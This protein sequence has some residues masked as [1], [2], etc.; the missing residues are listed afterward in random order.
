MTQTR[1]EPVRVLIIEDSDT[2]RYILSH[3]ISGDRRLQVVGAVSTAEEALMVLPKLS[4]DVISMDVR[5]PGM[6][7]IEATRRIMNE[8]PTPIVMIAGVGEDDAA[9][10][11]MQALRAGALALVE[12]PVGP[13]SEAFRDIAE[14]IRTQLYIMSQVPVIRRREAYVRE[15]RLRRRP[16]VT[17]PVPRACLETS[18]QGG[19]EI[20][21][22]AASTGGPPAFARLFSQ[23]PVD[24]P[25]P[26]VLVQHMGARFMDS[27][28]SWLDS[29][30]P[31]PVRIAAD[32]EMPESG[33]IHVAPG[34]CHL[35]VSLARRLSVTEDAPYRGQRPSANRLFQSV[36]ETY[37]PTAVGVL[38]TGMGDDGAEGLLA[39]RDAGAFTMAEDESSAVVYGMPQVAM[40][41]GAVCYSGP[42]DAIAG[43]LA[44][45]GSPQK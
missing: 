20:I 11:S 41:L 32:G 17:T 4:P 5:L 1:A 35:R 40:R 14:T 42:L 29:V 27:F 23:F 44:I 21:A 12:K 28:A 8:H 18:G 15:V 34:G 39:L 13:G 38:L 33:V 16:P 22:I 26:I 2:V 19:P 6:D 25:L 3:I 9:S 10:L 36:A 7:G 31:L 30:V 45:L 43:K 24:F 37:G